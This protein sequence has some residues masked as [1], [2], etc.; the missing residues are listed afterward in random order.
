MA[1]WEEV[2]RRMRDAFQ[3][4]RDDPSE[5][6]LTIPRQAGSAREQRVMVR[7]YLAFESEIVEFRSAF[8]ELAGSDPEQ[9][10]RD[11]LDL[12]LGAIALH[13]RYLVVVHRELLEP[14]SMDDVLLLLTQVSLLAD[15]L[16]ERRGSDRF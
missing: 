12:P 7:R 5:F 4:D 13:G 3:L 8:G 15:Q 6:A 1:D 14:L 2:R 9:L 16:E 10:L 11:S